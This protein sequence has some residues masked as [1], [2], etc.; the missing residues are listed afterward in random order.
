VNCS[1]AAR[2]RVRRPGPARGRAVRSGLGPAPRPERFRILHLLLESVGYDGASG[3]LQLSFYPLGI[4]SL[5]AEAAM[6]GS[7][8]R[9]RLDAGQHDWHG[10]RAGRQHASRHAEHPD[11]Q[12]ACRKR[13]G[14]L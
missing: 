14:R 10:R 13:L 9:W 8:P 7:R 11:P 6:I 4:T 3:E 1:G 12:I 5:A 2:D